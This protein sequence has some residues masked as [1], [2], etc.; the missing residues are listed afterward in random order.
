[1]NKELQN[2]FATIDSDSIAK[3][4]QTQSFDIF[5]KKCLT[6]KKFFKHIKKSFNFPNYFGMNWSAFIDCMSNIEYKDSSIFIF[7]ADLLFSKD[8]Q[9]IDTTNDFIGSMDFVI[10]RCK[11]KKNRGEGLY[12]QEPTFDLFVYL[13]LPS[14]N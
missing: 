11:S 2:R 3:Y 13:V 5:G 6:E 4:K 8:R 1:M 10:D 12:A 7:D 9:P 14:N